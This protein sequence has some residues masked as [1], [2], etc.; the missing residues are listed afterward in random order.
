MRHEETIA[1]KFGDIN[2]GFIK[3]QRTKTNKEV[4]S[5]TKTSNGMRTIPFYVDV[6]HLKN[7]SFYLFP[8][9]NDVSYFKKSWRSLLKKAKVRYRTIKNTRHTFATHVLKD[10]IVS[11][12][13]LAGL[14]GHAKVSTTFTYYA[15]VI[16]SHDIELSDKL[17]RQSFVSIEKEQKISNG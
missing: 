17:R 11:V 2:N 1:L 7:N 16:D 10:G 14:L 3:V 4:R 6:E 13:E 12:N 5:K 15:S 8:H 9:I